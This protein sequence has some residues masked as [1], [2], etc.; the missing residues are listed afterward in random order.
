MQ[1][2][3]LLTAAASPGLLFIVTLNMATQFF[4]MGFMTLVMTT[5]TTTATFPHHKVSESSNCNYP[6]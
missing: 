4:F 1:A 6:K 3:N 2:I 5:P